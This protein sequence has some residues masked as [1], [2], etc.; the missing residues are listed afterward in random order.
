MHLDDLV[1]I[2]RQFC[3][4]LPSPKLNLVHLSA[5]PV[6]PG[7]FSHLVRDALVDFSIVSHHLSLAQLAHSCL[8]Q[9]AKYLTESRRYS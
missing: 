7:I 3:G 5:A 6:V 9:W 1:R 4:N 2:S 8:L